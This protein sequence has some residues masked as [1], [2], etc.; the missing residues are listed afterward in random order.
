MRTQWS[1]SI[2]TDTRNYIYHKMTCCLIPYVVLE[3]HSSKVLLSVG[4]VEKVNEELSCVVFVS[5]TKKDNV[6]Y[7]L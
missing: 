6:T 7:V 5:T 1:I 4:C 3:G 2:F